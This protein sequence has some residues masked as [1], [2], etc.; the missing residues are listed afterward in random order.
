[1]NPPLLLLTLLSL[2]AVLVSPA[3]AGGR[4]APDWYP[5]PAQDPYARGADGFVDSY[6][7]R[8]LPLDAMSPSATGGDWWVD[9]DRGERPPETGF[10]AYA[11]PPVGGPGFYDAYAPPAVGGPGL[12]DAYAPPPIGGPGLYDAFAREPEPLPERY[13][14]PAAGWPGQPPS[15][16]PYP[17]RDGAGPLY[18]GYAP[19]PLPRDLSPFGPAEYRFRGDE[20][21]GDG[22]GAEPHPGGWRFRP[23][24][25]QE[26]DRARPGDPWRPVRREA[27][28]EMRGGRHAG[29]RPQPLPEAFGYEPDNWFRR[30][31]G[32]RP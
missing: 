32:E 9:P 14:P 15:P 10:D 7:A 12:Y 23:L 13:A 3:L 4:E 28:G 16:L 6:G 20:R 18:P 17:D 29:E 1:M 26:R 21:F 25:E 22:R 27:R 5:A 11:P 30:Y 31:Y 19:G 8:Y 24:T 2:P